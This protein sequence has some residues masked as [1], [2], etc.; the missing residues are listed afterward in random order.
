MSLPQDEGDGV[1][2]P[3]KSNG[4]YHAPEEEKG[5]P[6]R[7]G[8]VIESAAPAPTADGESGV[9]TVYRGPEA[10]PQSAPEPESEA[11]RRDRQDRRGSRVPEGRA[12]LEVYKRVRGYLE[13]YL[14]LA[15]PSL[16][17]V[18]AWTMATHLTDVW[19]EFPHLGITSP[20]KGCGKT[21]LLGLL[22]GMCRS[23][24]NVVGISPAA[25]YRTIAKL[26]PTLLMDEAQ[27]LTR[28]GSETTEV[29]REVLCG[30]IE[31]DATIVRCVGQNHEPT[32]FPIYCP[33]AVALIGNL[34]GVLADRSLPVR[35][36]K[37]LKT[38]KVRKHQRRVAK[39]EGEAVRAEL[40]GWA[41]DPATAEA[42]A[43]AYAELE[44]FDLTS[45]RMADLLLPLQ[46]VLTVVAQAA[47]TFQPGSPGAWSAA[48]P[49]TLLKRYAGGVEE[50][51]HEAEMQSP[52]VRLLAAC[53]EVFEQN[54]HY[55]G[56]GDPFLA[57]SVL[58]GLLITREE[59]PWAHWCRGEPINNEGLA[60]L[61]RPFGIR[62]CRNRKQTAR[63]YPLTAFADAWARYLPPS[64]ETPSSPSEPSIPSGEDEEVV[65]E[66][67]GSDWI[68]GLD[69]YAGDGE[70]VEEVLDETVEEMVDETILDE[71]ATAGSKEETTE[72]RVNRKLRELIEAYARKAKDTAEGGDE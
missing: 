65:E 29:L 12:A 8:D 18:S 1:T 39:P 10:E 36:R 19:D 54:S 47:D 63:G 23:A 11:E 21:R 22:T 5:D 51:E 67:D 34:D 26:Q 50:Q 17:A 69:G 56:K 25:V 70:P 64:L 55:W 32:A 27:C 46:A 59:E 14:V 3:E 49:L 24:L 2:G 15:E 7:P 31:K 43:R 4:E 20:E 53:R 6:A 71:T 35:M 28:R 62:S 37:K 33:K 61:L 41:N 58:I 57:T 48:R 72:D 60:K 42:V 40:A 66:A 68:D 9:L 30:S 45:D 38:E 52:G 13:A 44:P 16:A